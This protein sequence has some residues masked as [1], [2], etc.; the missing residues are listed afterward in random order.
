MALAKKNNSSNYTEWI[1]HNTQIAFCSEP[2]RDSP[3]AAVFTGNN[4]AI[5]GMFKRIAEQFTAMFR[6]KAFL[7]WY[8]G[9]GMD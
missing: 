9:L 4:S 5:V 3:N 6:R 7:H 1:P 8:T 2:P